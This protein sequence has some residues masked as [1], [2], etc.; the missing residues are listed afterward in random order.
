[1]RLDA[2]R[3]SATSQQGVPLGALR[4]RNQV[5]SAGPALFGGAARTLTLAPTPVQTISDPNVRIIDPIPVS[6][7]N[8][9]KVKL[10]RRYGKID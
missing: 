3:Q 2:R 1:M 8:K 10:F 5:A 9:D 7:Y 4:L 6:A